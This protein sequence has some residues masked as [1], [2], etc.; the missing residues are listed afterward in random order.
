MGWSR[1]SAFILLSNGSVYYL[2]PILPYN[3]MVSGRLFEQLGENGTI[4]FSFQI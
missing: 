2:C 4:F 3:V 1:L